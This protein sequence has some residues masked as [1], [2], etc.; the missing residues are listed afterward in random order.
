MA[1]QNRGTVL[2]FKGVSPAKRLHPTEKPIE[3][4]KEIM[5]T[6][7]FSICLDPFM[8]SGSTLVAAKSLWRHCIG[9]E[10]EE[11]YCEI[12]ANR[13]RQMVMDLGI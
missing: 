8:G 9:I 6:S 12:A 4:I 2:T 3:L 13:C 7:G 1:H 5:I 10:I 11:K